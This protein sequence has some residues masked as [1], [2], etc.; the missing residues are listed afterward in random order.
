MEQAADVPDGRR[1][2]GE[3]PMEECSVECERVLAGDASFR[4]GVG[5]FVSEQEV[6]G[7]AHCN[8]AA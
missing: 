1:S 4:Q 8:G 6:E 5:V 3:K 7:R 2:S